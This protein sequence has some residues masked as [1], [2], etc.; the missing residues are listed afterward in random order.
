MQNSDYGGM[1]NV[2]NTTILSSRIAPSQHL[3]DLGCACRHMSP[4]TCSRY[5][6]MEGVKIHE[7]YHNIVR[8]AR[9]AHR[10]F[11]VCVVSWRRQN[12]SQVTGLTPFE[13]WLNEAVTVYVQRLREA[14]RARARQ[15]ALSAVS[16]AG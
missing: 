7:Y 6:Y 10:S 4:A 16:I 12:G 5:I 11:P 2:G 3:P 15:C 9:P 13:I 14:R 1:E 8:R